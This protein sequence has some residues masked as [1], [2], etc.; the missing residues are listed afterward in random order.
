MELE[1]LRNAVQERTDDRSALSRGAR[2]VGEN[3]ADLPD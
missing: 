1:E 3:L 2:E